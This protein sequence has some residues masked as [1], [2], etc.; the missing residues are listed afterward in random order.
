MCGIAGVL[1]KRGENVVPV[2][3]KMLSC[4]TKRGPDGAG[5]AAGGR[6]VQSGSLA[7]LCHQNLSGTAALGHTRLAIVG[8][9]CGKQP[10]SSCDGRLTVEHNGEIYNYKELRRSLEQS[11][12]FTTKTDSEVLVHLLE[13]NIRNGNLLEAIRK[14]VSQLDGIYALAIKD[15]D[16]GTIALVRDRIGV[17]QLYYG[18]APGYIAFASERKPLW[19]VGIR[20][21]TERVLPASAV[22]LT[23]DGAVKS[24]PVAEPV[25][26]VAK[27]A[28]VVYRTVSSAVAAYQKALLN[29]VKKRTQ[30]FQRIG[31]IFSGGIDSVLIAYLAKQMVPDVICFTCGMQNSSD[32]AYAK[33]IAENLGLKLLVNELTQ[34]KV[35]ALIPEIV[36]I[37]EDNNAGQVE[38]AIPVYGAVS[39]AHEKGIRMM[40]TGQA[41]DELFGGYSWY[42]KVAA[43]EGYR[44]LRQHMIEDLLLLYKETLEREDKITM[45]QSVE[46][47]EP[48]LDLEVIKT[49]MQ[50][51]LRLNVK[52]PT[53]GFGKQIHRKL[54]VKLGI[55]RDIAYRAKEAA[56]HGSGVHGALDAIARKHGFDESTIPES[57]LNALSSRERI[58]SSQRYG[59]L[60]D[61]QKIWTADPHVQMY[62]DSVSRSLPTFE[63]NIIAGPKKKPSYL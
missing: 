21:P 6:I 46:L 23:P 3:G 34:D 53:D 47:R 20:E 57:Y 17:R 10:F 5:I 12:K 30:D 18:Q 37:I 33:M 42:A 39:L 43:K 49:A 31:I 35:E 61:E 36:N 24:Y 2:V 51:D 29:S 62:L 50:I 14:T 38:V 60:F 54:A 16:T 8:G 13:D 41:A 9:S 52:G 28:R 15:E 44:K 11:H 59:Y 25:A 58:G 56:Q 7:S 19:A 22:I 45:A 26:V 48:F 40:L 4:M 32:V 27:P 55:P 1:S 63:Q